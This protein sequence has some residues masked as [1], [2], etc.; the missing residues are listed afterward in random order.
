MRKIIGQT[1]FFLLYGVYFLTTLFVSDFLGYILSPVVVFMA[2]YFIFIEYCHK[3]PT[4]YLKLSGVF[5]SA[6][7]FSW[8]IG[9]L[10]LAVDYFLKIDGNILG[11]ISD[12]IYGFTNIFLLIVVTRFLISRL[13]TLDHSL[14][15][16]NLFIVTSCVIILIWIIFFDKKIENIVLLTYNIFE[17]FIL[18]M[19]FIIFIEIA[20][21]LASIRRKKIPFTFVIFPL[22]VMVFVITDMVYY[23]LYFYSEYVINSVID[24][25]FVLSFVLFVKGLAGGIKNYEDFDLEESDSLFHNSYWAILFPLLIVIFD[26]F[27]FQALTFMLLMLTLYFLVSGY[28]QKG[29][30]KQELI[31][32]QEE[33]NRSLEERIE[34]RTKE[35]NFIVKTHRI[36]G[37]FNA[38]YFLGRLENTINTLDEN[39]K[40]MLLSIEIDRY[41]SMK[42]IYGDSVT[43]IL[44]KKIAEK[45][46]SSL[47]LTQD[48]LLATYEADIFMLSVKGFIDM[49]NGEELADKIINCCSGFYQ[50]EDYN[51]KISFN[52]GVSIYPQ[53]SKN[54]VELVKNAN[55]AMNYSKELGD[56]KIMSF[57]KKV[58]DLVLHKNAIAIQLKKIDYN[59]EFYLNFQPQILAADNSIIGFEVLLR[60]KNADGEIVPPGEF[61]PIAEE[62]GS[63]VGIGDWVLTESFRQMKDWENKS[64]NKTKFAINVS[65]KQLCGKDFVGKLKS[66]IEYFKVDPSYVELEITES[67]QLESDPET[68]EIINDIRELGISVAIDDFGTGYS[69]LYYFKN[70]PVDRLKISK[71]LIDKIHIDPFEYSVTKSVIDLGKVKG[72]KVIAEGV[73]TEEQFRCLQELGCDEIQGYY[74]GRPESADKAYERRHK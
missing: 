16:L 23:Y 47:S 51:I 35:L 60:W 68:L 31:N 70:L 21:Y 12:Y 61:I 64:K 63:I 69:S 11:I 44:L 38:G 33:L 50:V 53:D 74:F 36:T 32:Y 27:N 24:A 14:A 49:K 28:I 52:I 43:Q 4:K 29:I 25:V 40:V 56:N 39:E 59:K 2:T 72:V 18:I 62:T 46:K 9:D 30:Y 66:K 58:G 17:F 45:M 10:L 71:P 19:N 73:E 7:V 54:K 55:I 6:A 26:G 1:I 13:R 48:V 65:A 5:L 8:G 20:V 57:D 22:G 15:M 41:R 34:E 37:L 3:A 42:M 67:V